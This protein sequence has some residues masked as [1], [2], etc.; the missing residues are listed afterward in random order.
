MVVDA[1]DD[2]LSKCA[3]C[4]TIAFADLSTQM[5]L[6]TDTA[7]TLPREALDRLSKQAA[8]AL[9]LNGRTVLGEKPGQAA[10]LADK[11][12]VHVFLRASDEPDDVLCCV[13]T[14][15]VNLDRFLADATDCVNRISS[16]QSE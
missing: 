3:E 2:L 11:S 6:V 10:V 1:L 5:I 4:R 14:P 16:G 15:D 13:C 7:S 9:G 12:A 8:E